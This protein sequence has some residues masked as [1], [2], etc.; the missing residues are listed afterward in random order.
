MSP[1]MG[2]VLFTVIVARTVGQGPFDPPI[3]FTKSR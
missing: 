3:S 1:R 2:I